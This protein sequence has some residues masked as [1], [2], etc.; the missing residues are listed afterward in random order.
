MTE[1]RAFR[2]RFRGGVSPDRVPEQLA[3]WFAGQIAETWYR[4]LPYETELLPSRWRAWKRDHPNAVPPPGYEWLDDP[5][6]PRHPSEA[7][8]RE[9]RRLLARA[10]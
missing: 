1:P 5:A 3:Q 7:E 6:D 8:V 10:K 4:L 2:R 9:A